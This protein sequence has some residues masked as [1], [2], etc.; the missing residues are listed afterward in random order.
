MASISLLMIV[1]L[2]AGISFLVCAVLASRDARVG[3]RMFGKR[4][5]FVGVISA[6]VFAAI[7]LLL[8][9]WAMMRAPAPPGVN[10][11]LSVF[12]LMFGAG[13]VFLI[14]TT[15]GA[16]GYA[17]TYPRFEGTHRPIGQSELN[18]E[19]RVDET[20]NPYQPPTI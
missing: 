18:I 13:V 12:G 10:L 17:M 8:F 16:I 20:G 5:L 1:G 19:T 4:I 9:I 11:R 15:G 7:V 6:A 2:I 14:S 3:Q